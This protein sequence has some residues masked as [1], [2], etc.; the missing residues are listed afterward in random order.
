MNERVSH[1]GIIIGIN[2][3]VPNGWL[4]PL[5]F[6]RI[7]RQTSDEG[8]AKVR[9]ILPHSEGQSDATTN[10]YPCFYEISYQEMRD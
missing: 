3:T 5:S 9:L 1:D 10:V 6:V 4:T 7:G 2:A 8:I